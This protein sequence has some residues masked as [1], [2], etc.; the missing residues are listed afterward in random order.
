MRLFEVNE[1]DAISSEITHA[2]VLLFGKII[3]ISI[4][5]VKC[6]IKN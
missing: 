6:E 5:K 2:G 3:P 1:T 4:A